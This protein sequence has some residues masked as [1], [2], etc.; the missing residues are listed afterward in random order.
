MTDEEL[1]TKTAEAAAIAP[2]PAIFDD[3]S[4]AARRHLS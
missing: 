1:A 2:L 4:D 3:G